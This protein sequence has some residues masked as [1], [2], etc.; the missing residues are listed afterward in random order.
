MI[1]CFDCHMTDHDTNTLVAHRISELL[2]HGDVSS[3]IS[4][5]R[6][7]L[8]EQ[9][10][11][12]DALRYLGLAHILQHQFP[13]ADHFL[14]R[15]LRLA[16]ADPGL[17]SAL[18]TVRVNQSVYGDA[19]QLFS[20]ALQIQPTHTDALSNLAAALTLLRQ[21]AKAKSYLDRL[22]RVLPYSADAHVRASINT[23]NLND[24]EDAIG[25]GRKAV[26][27]APENSPAR[28]ALAEALEA[29]GRFK[30]AKYQYLAVLATEPRQVTALSKLLSLK[31][32]HIAEQY[33]CAV[34]GLL[35]EPQSRDTDRVQLSIALAQYYDFRGQYDSAFEHLHAGNT[36]RF[37]N[38]PFNSAAHSRAVDRLIHT[39]TSAAL[40]S[41]PS[42]NVR[43]K[44]PVF[45]VGMPRSGTTLVEQILSSHS[46]VAAG[47][48]LP[49]IINIA[50]QITGTGTTYP[51]A[52][53][54]LDPTALAR[55][56]RQY[57]DKLDA[58]STS[59]ARVTDKMP[60]NFMHLWL[61]VALLPD[62]TIIHCRR[63]VRDICLSCYFTSFSQ[64]LQFASDLEAL[65][66][67]CL[68]YRRIMQHWRQ[69]LPGRFLEV[70]YER[71][72]GNTED[73]VR[74][75]LAFCGLPWDPTCMQ[76]YRTDRGVRTPSRWQVR[77]P[78][79]RH[80]VG[81]WRNYESHLQPLVSALL[82]AI[83]E[84]ALG[85]SSLGLDKS[86]G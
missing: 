16:P 7:L 18:G 50:S 11:N 48:E 60:F 28:L 3:A 42:H 15:A 8:N 76:F 69:V 81:R 36:I 39:C 82:P 73:S 54:E 79:Y 58:I 45:I 29:G 13:E 6:R 26:R 49:A 80:S 4:H 30:Q 17:L 32:T 84:D 31:G 74:E 41:L 14:S 56:A 63:D 27:L 19:I 37:K 33:V 75:L 1:V 10:D 46:H 47:G 43:S 53:R 86:G 72:V 20:R 77:Q 40:R 78:I 5:C 64:E 44:K 65:A 59:A 21:P 66:R 70:D 61:I 71:L 35:A 12:L 9:P 67:Y 57:L 22:I 68:D 62:A 25:Y 83:Q 24:V 2:K 55:L 51:E 38:H 85:V 34:R 52:T 23:L